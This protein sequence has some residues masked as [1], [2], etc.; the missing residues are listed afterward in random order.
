[1]NTSNKKSYLIENFLLANLRM[2][3]KVLLLMND[4]VLY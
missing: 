3:V 1:M 2:C 4:T